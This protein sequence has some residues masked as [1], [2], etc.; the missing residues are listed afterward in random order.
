MLSTHSNSISLD[1]PIVC[2]ESWRCTVQELLRRLL[3]PIM[4]GNFVVPSIMSCQIGPP[5]LLLSFL[6]FML[7]QATNEQRNKKDQQRNISIYMYMY[8]C[9]YVVL[10]VCAYVCAY[11]YIYTCIC[12]YMYIYMFTYL[13]SACVHLHPAVRA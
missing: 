9:M 3:A 13:C 10:Y 6:G 11:I 8:A 1:L 7:L 12:V 4:P 5:H 2:S